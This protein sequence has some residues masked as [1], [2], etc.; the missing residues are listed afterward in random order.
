[1]FVFKLK[2]KILEIKNITPQTGSILG[3]TYL[4]LIGSY[5][6]HDNNLPA[7]IEISG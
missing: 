7:K 3:E 4:T 5:F 2:I 6:Y 1:M